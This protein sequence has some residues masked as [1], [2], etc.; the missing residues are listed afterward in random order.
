MFKEIKLVLENKIALI[1]LIG[2]ILII[3]SFLVPY[4]IS[5]GITDI[6]IASQSDV[7]YW[8]IFGTEGQYFSLN[9][10]FRL[11][12]ALSI[13]T[14][15]FAFLIGLLSILFGLN[16]LNQKFFGELIFIFSVLISISTSLLTKVIEFS[17]S[18]R[19]DLE[20]FLDSNAPFW[21]YRIYGFGMY[22]IGIAIFLIIVGS[23]LSLKDSRKSFFYLALI[24]LIWEILT[25]LFSFFF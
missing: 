21:G 8:G 3:I 7:W 13:I 2:S 22:A 5:E 12:I 23:L 14:L 18:I 11:N 17:F 24:Y 9:V 19:P 16:K 4:A 10:P 1:P 15:F 6:S 25:Q 20:P